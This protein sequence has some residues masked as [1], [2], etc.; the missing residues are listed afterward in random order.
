MA[1]LPE[2]LLSVAYNLVP[3][4]QYDGFDE[5]F[6]ELAGQFSVGEQYQIKNELLR[7]CEPFARVIDLRGKVSGDCRKFIHKGRI[8]YLDESAIEVFNAGLE[9]FGQYTLGI[10]EDVNNTSNNYRV[11]QAQKEQKRLNAAKAE[12]QR[13]SDK[14]Q[15]ILASR[16]SY[17]KDDYPVHVIQFGDYFNREEERMNYSV[18]AIL[19]FADGR[20]IEA[21]TKDFSIKGLYLRVGLSEKVEPDD[22]VKVKLQDQDKKYEALVGEGIEYQIKRIEYIDQ[23]IWLGLT[24]TF[25]ESLAQAPADAKEATDD[26]FT[27]YARELIVSNKYVYKV[28]LD[29]AIDA[30]LKQGYEQVFFSRTA[31]I[32]LFVETLGNQYRLRYVLTTG[33]NDANYKFWYDEAEQSYLSA[34]YTPVRLKALLKAE[35]DESIL[36][37]FSHKMQNQILFFAAFDSQLAQ[38]PALKRLFIGYGATKDSWKVFKIK[39]VAIDQQAIGALFVVPPRH[40][41]GAGNDADNEQDDTAQVLQ[42]TDIGNLTHAILMTEISNELSTQVFKMRGYDAALMTEITQFQLHYN[43]SGLAVRRLNFG[44]DELRHEPR[45]AYKTKVLVTFSNGV[46]RECTS[47]DFSARGLQVLLP[48]PVDVN[49]HEV[50]ECAFPLLQQI[51]KKLKL[52]QLEYLVVGTENH[53]KVLYLRAISQDEVVHHGVKFF[54]D[55]IKR[56]RHKLTL[57]ADSK[58]DALLVKNLKNLYQQALGVIPFYVNRVDGKL[59]ITQWVKSANPHPLLDLFKTDQIMAKVNISSLIDNNAFDIFISAANARLKAV[60]QNQSIDLF[61]ASVDGEGEGKD[62]AQESP[63]FIIR[64]DSELGTPELQKA[65]INEAQASGQF[66]CIRVIMSLVAKVDTRKIAEELEYIHHY[67]KHKSKTIAQLLTRINNVGEMVDITGFVLSYLD[68]V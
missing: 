2:E 25:S 23:V 21:V 7:I 61:I 36:Y 16:L 67:A 6:E 60:N 47:V 18:Q 55:L 34:L 26:D 4:Y 35:T 66:Y 49:N 31:T 41:V 40:G 46:R 64:A 3:V 33:L 19:S 45:F 43:D 65:F 57:V 29:N 39:R 27:T 48:G 5:V 62:G 24:R 32:P 56:N 17:S 54:Y 44:L 11:L 37:C 63:R 14:L 53:Q 30:A 12:Q 52:S 38:D 13:K 42:A 1:Q 10:W 28:N 22:I 8:H 51:T 68:E 58:E 59:R 15:Q 9:L 20:E 50:V